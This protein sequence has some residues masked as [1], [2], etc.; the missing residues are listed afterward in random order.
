MNKEK[1]FEDSQF[2]EEKSAI[3]NIP[4]TLRVKRSAFERNMQNMST[5][6]TLTGL[7][8]E[9]SGILI[10]TFLSLQKLQETYLYGRRKPNNKL[11]IQKELT[12]I[13]TE[14][15]DDLISK[16]DLIDKQNYQW[17]DICRSLF[18]Y[19]SV[20]GSIFGIENN[21][22]KMMKSW[23]DDY[24]Y[25]QK[26]KN[27]DLMEEKLQDAKVRAISHL[28]YLTSIDYDELPIREVRK[29]IAKIGDLNMH[30]SEDPDS[31]SSLD[32]LWNKNLNITCEMDDSAIGGMAKLNHKTLTQEKKDRLLS[33][34]HSKIKWYQKV[35]LIGRLFK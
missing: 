11:L 34:K 21:I 4:I 20:F 12:K 30:I 29:R 28:S 2:Y 13:F 15:M 27:E 18:K 5:D 31:Y 22:T 9:K 19:F 10:N 35:P 24:D 1:H 16:W 25:A 26:Y 3:R 8:N 17:R 23:F 14:T 7:F 6:A 32:H 33:H